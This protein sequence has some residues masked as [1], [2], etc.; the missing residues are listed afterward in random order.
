ML[1]G[2]F[3][4]VPAVRDLAIELDVLRR[5]V[6]LLEDAVASMSAGQK[7]EGEPAAEAGGEPAGRRGGKREKTGAASVAEPSVVTDDA[8]DAG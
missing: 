4:V 2:S 5:R 3:D 7:S 6:R 1:D 8:D